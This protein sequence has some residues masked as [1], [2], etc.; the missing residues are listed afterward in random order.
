M[1]TT[2][3]H[4]EPHKMPSSTH[5]PSG[6]STAPSMQAIIVNRVSIVEP[7]LAPIV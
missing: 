5:V 7:E 4:F 2:L 6:N 1:T 3:K